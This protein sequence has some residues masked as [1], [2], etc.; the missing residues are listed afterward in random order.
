[1][2]NPTRH[3][4]L[5]A[6]L[7]LL[8]ALPLYFSAACSSNGAKDQE[9]FS[10]VTVIGADVMPIVISSDLSVG[11]ERLSV[12]LIKGN[13]PILNG[14]ITFALY[15]IEND[16]GTLTQELKARD[17]HLG[18]AVT[19]KHEGGSTE[20]HEAGSIGVY[21]ANVTFD[22]PG[23][24]GLVVSGKAGGKDIG[25]QQVRFTVLP[26]EAG[27]AVG[28]K[29]PLSVQPILRDVTE[30]S[31]IDTSSSPDPAMHSMTIAEAVSSGKP[32]LIA[33]ATPSYCRSRVCGP[34]KIL[35]DDLA[36]TY[37]QQVNFVHIEPYDLVKARTG[38]LEPIS[39]LE[40]EWRLTTEPWLFIIGTDGTVTA[41]FEAAVEREELE[42][43]LRGAIA[44]R[45]P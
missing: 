44:G 25:K 3:K 40:N 19:E 22:A 20:T 35:V 27:I 32:T 1:M 37:A 28:A 38:T 6:G 18:E 30:L 8:L 14:D 33:F 4:V 42:E 15:K 24:W 12:G 36:K 21:V 31:A 39:L 7:F 41:K 26:E 16:Q 23:D 13:E 9:E 10:D 43:A 5:K 2:R 29:A 11:T 17:I 34:V 45:A